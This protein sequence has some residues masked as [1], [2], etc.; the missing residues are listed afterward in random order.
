VRLAHQV[1]ECD[2]LGWRERIGNTT[3]RLPAAQATCGTLEFPG[4]HPAA[5][6]DAVV[7]PGRFSGGSADELVLVRNILGFGVLIEGCVGVGVQSVAACQGG[8]EPCFLGV[9]VQHDAHGEGTAVLLDELAHRERVKSVG[10][11]VVQE[12]HWKRI[13][14]KMCDGFGESGREKVGL[15][16]HGSLPLQL[17]CH[18]IQTTLC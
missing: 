3:P 13:R 16:F 4:T 7:L 2:A 9:D 6:A 15:L 12:N 17:K 10:A 14:I 11:G 5:K 8:E 18:S 1:R